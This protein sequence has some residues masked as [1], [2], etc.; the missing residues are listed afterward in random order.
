VGKN[1]FVVTHWAAG[2]EFKI[3][4]LYPVGCP[5]AIQYVNWKA[6]LEILVSRI[7]FT[8]LG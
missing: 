5:E 7:R 4:N 2:N 1:P 3:R 8:I 6:L